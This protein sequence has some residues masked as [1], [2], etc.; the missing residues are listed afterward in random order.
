[1]YTHYPCVFILLY[2]S[3]YHCQQ[4]PNVIPFHLFVL[5]TGSREPPVMD[6]TTSISP[7]GV[8]IL[9]VF[10]CFGDQGSMAT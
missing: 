4:S 1:M 10:A 8:F 7:V 6:S 9:L 3:I 5:Q 2:E